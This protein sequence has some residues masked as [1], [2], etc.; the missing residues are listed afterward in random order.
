MT[1]PGCQTSNFLAASEVIGGFSPGR[2]GG[3]CH[4]PARAP[5]E[6]R[7]GAVFSTKCPRVPIEWT[8]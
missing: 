2:Q 8:M 6:P 3:H 4:T 1:A 7:G 5:P